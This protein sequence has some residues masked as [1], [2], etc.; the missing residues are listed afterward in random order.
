VLQFIVGEAAQTEWAECDYYSKSPS[1][2]IHCQWNPTERSVTLSSIWVA[3]RHT[4]TASNRGTRSR[5]KHPESSA[6]VSRCFILFMSTYIR[7]KV[8]TYLSVMKKQQHF[9][10]VQNKTYLYRDAM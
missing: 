4:A 2:W 7:K 6:K 3:G 10:Y 8:A 1:D 5:A 9:L